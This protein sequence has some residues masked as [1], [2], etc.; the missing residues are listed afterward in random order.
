[1]K[2]LIALFFTAWLAGCVSPA[3]NTKSKGERFDLI[4]K[5]YQKDESA[6]TC[7]VTAEV[8]HILPDGTINRYN[9]QST[10]NTCQEAEAD[11]R[12]GYEALKKP[13]N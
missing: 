10:K 9:L 13:D 12:K 4:F 3:G 11:I 6:G 8:N 1:M 5:E 2:F 7:T